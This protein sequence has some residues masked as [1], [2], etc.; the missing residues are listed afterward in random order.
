M[1][2]TPTTVMP[3]QPTP[4]TTQPPKVI[5][6]VQPGQPAQVI[7]QPTAQAPAAPQIQPGQVQPVAAQPAPQPGMNAQVLQAGQ[8]AAIQGFQSPTLDLTSEA[9]RR[10][11]S[12]PSMGYN[13]SK[14]VQTGMDAFNLNLAQ[15]QEKLRRETAPSSHSGE[16]LGALV[17]FAFR[18]AQEGAMTKAQLEQEANKFD[19]EALYNAIQQ[20]RDTSESER[21]RFATNVGALV[22]IRGAAEGERAQNVQVAESALDRGLKIALA[23][24]DAQLQTTLQDLQN[25]QQTGILLQTQDFEAAQA[26]LNRK[27]QEFTSQGDWANVLEV[28]R[29]KGEFDQQAQAA[30]QQWSTGERIASQ[31]YNTTER[32][33][34]QDYQT[35]LKYIDQKINEALQNNDYANQQRLQDSRAQLELQMQTQEFGQEQKMAYLQQ[36]LQEATADNDVGRQK[37]IMQ[38]ASGLELDQMAQ[39]FGYD[40]AL[41]EIQGNIQVALQNNEFGNAMAMMGAEQNFTAKEAALDRA[42]EESRIALQGRQIFLQGQAMTFEQIEMAVEAGQIDPQ[43]AVEAVQASASQYGIDIK[44]ADPNAIYQQLDSDF[45]QFQYQFAQTNPNLANFGPGGE[46]IGLKD[47][48]AAEF[49]KA[50]NEVYWPSV[51]SKTGT[52]QIQPPAVNT[53]QSGAGWSDPRNDPDSPYFSIP[54]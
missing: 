34:T 30:Q 46:F 35:G 16:R 7:P 54:G 18:G 33:S 41:Q 5:P 6:Q 51:S 17:D 29:L 3:N 48:G 49:Y 22:D 9:T 53:T 11:L 20:G 50:V 28:T 25:K 42:L 40:S 15:Q 2:T 10:L 1:A 21:S 47:E 23:N 31:N 38:Y 14:Q 24:Q 45:R 8:Q 52:Q 32:L 43:A 19:R 36:Q 12:Q 27:L 44:A 39:Q 4:V 26:D 37:Q 13:A